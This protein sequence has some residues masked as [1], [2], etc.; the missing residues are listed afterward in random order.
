VQSA[1]L[2]EEV[3]AAL[4]ETGLPPACLVLETTEA[5]V[6]PNLQQSIDRLAR[7]AETGVRLAID[8]FGS[9]YSSLAYLRRYPVHQLKI[10][11]SFLHHQRGDSE[12]LSLV[13]GMV[14]LGA[15]LGLDVVVEGVEK[16][17]QLTRLR[18]RPH[19]YAQGF[20]YSRPVP[21]EEFERLPLSRPKAVT[22]PPA[23]RRQT[24]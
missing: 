7:L 10:D 8:D 9:G 12:D 11:R 16:D 14:R 23:A 5:G 15:E 1:D 18:R 6:L 19:L 17:W 21:A 22:E 24:S 2:V 20:L 4:A 3:A 13:R